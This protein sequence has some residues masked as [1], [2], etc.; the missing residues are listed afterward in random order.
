[1]FDVAVAPEAQLGAR[2]VV[3]AVPSLFLGYLSSQIEDVG[4]DAAASGVDLWGVTSGGLAE[5]SLI[6]V[7]VA[8][9][10]AER[11][12]EMVLLAAALV[13]DIAAEEDN[14]FVGFAVIVRLVRHT[15]GADRV[16]KEMPQTLGNS[17]EECG[18]RWE[19]M[20]ASF[21]WLP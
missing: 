20:V 12:K 4:L 15:Y 21:V 19:G 18:K 13:A 16:Q 10:G 3:H 14:T 11:R 7:D 8:A 2:F 9:V 6:D 17:T 1:M 5:K